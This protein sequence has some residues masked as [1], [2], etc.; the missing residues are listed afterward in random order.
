M[1]A[2]EFLGFLRPKCRQVQT[3]DELL[4][5]L[6]EQ[7]S[8]R[9]KFGI[10][11]T[12]KDVHLG[13]L[14]PMMV[15]RQFLKLGHSADLV[16]GDFTARI[17]DPSMRS[18]KRTPITK[19]EIERNLVTYTEQIGA[20]VPLDRV[21]VH[22]NSSWLNRVS[23]ADVFAVFQEINL[24]EAI[25]REDFRSRVHAEHAVSLAEVCYGMLMGMDSSHLHSDVEIGGV[26][27]LLNFRQCR[28][29]MEG[30]GMR[31]ESVIMTPILE[32]TSGD[33][34]KMS[35]S[36]G[37]FIALGE[38]PSE[39]FGK[40]MSIPDRLIVPFILAFSDVHE[41]EVPSL[42]EFA[43]EQPL[44]AKKQLASIVVALETKRFEDGQRERELF[45]RKFSQKHVTA[46]ESS[47]LVVVQGETLLDALFRSGKF[48]SKSE[49]RTLFLQR[50]VRHIREGSEN[51]RIITDVRTP[52]HEACEG[53]LRVGKRTNFS[54][55]AMSEAEQ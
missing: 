24:A 22:R 11:P 34:S 41:T 20:F 49:L 21:T 46:E 15:M 52:A 44:E 25:Q 19:E 10:D 12:A 23:L 7:R 29:L 1:D 4:S 8:L 40:V 55:I 3:E 35:K 51:I 43:E 13:H 18:T 26:D 48:S 17:G 9:V 33:G 42:A 2:D 37:N 39:K 6:R 5:L 32:G 27:Q 36:K 45:E 30:K 28:K 47:P 38:S 14:V 16:I 54:V 31:P 53:V 50:A